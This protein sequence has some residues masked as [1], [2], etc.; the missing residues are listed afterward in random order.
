MKA[1]VVFES[2]FG[3][4]KET[5]GA[6]ADGLRAA[7]LDP[8]DVELAE[9]GTA[10]TE[11][12]GRADLVVVGAPTHAFGLSRPRTR[13]DAA[14]QS[15]HL[16]VSIGSGLREWLDDVGGSGEVWATSFDTRVDKPRLPGSA[17]KAAVRRLRRKG[18]RI[19]A[20]PESFRVDGTTGP[21]VAGE[22]DRARG[23]GAELVGMLAGHGPGP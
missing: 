4:T 10:P 22:L 9:V 14:R 17:A 8:S 13:A 12:A 6:V 18:F 2:M 16:L 21:L 3:N 1:L 11:V 19:L 7:G 20:P 23:W 5:A 15:D